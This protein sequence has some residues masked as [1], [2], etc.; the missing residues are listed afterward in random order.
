MQVF[1]DKTPT[2]LKISAHVA[3]PFHVFL[4][5]CSA[6][7]RSWFIE[8]EH[9]VVG[10]LSVKVSTDSIKDFS[11]VE[12]QSSVYCFTGTGHRRGPCRRDM[13][14]LLTGPCT[15]EAYIVTI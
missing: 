3:H 12:G 7:F 14:V 6:Q 11:T 9:T 13:T 8:H 10:S 1:S 5:K 4:M 2:T 15:T